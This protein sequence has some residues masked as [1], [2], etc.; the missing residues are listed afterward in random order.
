MA[1][2]LSVTSS[3]FV[4]SSLPFPTYDHYP[5]ALP[6]PSL[7]CPSLVPSILQILVGSRTISIGSWWPAAPF[8]WL[9]PA[10]VSGPT[11]DWLLHSIN[12]THTGLIIIVLCSALGSGLGERLEPCLHACMKAQYHGKCM[13]THTEVF[14]TSPVT[15]PVLSHMSGRK[16]MEWC[17]QKHKIYRSGTPKINWFI[18]FNP[19]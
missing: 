10:I 19:F 15:W 16:N 12:Y 13:T 6:P 8:T 1:F 18:D 9:L 11:T 17:M 7:W 5:Y 3:R 14:N 2:L 4:S